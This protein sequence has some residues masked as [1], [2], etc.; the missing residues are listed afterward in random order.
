VISGAVYETPRPGKG[1]SC[2]APTPTEEG[3]RR[4]VLSVALVNLAY[5]GVEFTV[6][7]GIGSVSLIADSI[8]FLE[9]Q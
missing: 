3:L 5:F 1:M 6:A 9:A 4:V 2:M 8:D 7:F